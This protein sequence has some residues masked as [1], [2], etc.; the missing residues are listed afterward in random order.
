MENVVLITTIVAATVAFITTAF[1][2]PELPPT[3]FFTASAITTAIVIATRVARIA[4]IA[5]ARVSYR[6]SRTRAR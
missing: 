5:S 1:V 2:F 3:T 4:A 6:A